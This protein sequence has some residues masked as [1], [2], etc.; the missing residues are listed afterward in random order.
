MSALT[1]LLTAFPNCRVTIASSSPRRKARAGDRRYTKR[2]GWQVRE[3]CVVRYGNGQVI[4][5]QV[6][7][8]R[9]VYEWVRE[10]PQAAP[11][12]TL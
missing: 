3:Q 1:D 5:H 6:R 10:E 9:P 2:Y 11:P 4:G 12:S 7:N 8:G